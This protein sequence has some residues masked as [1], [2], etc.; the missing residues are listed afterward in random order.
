MLLDNKIALITGAMGSFGQAISQAFVNEGASLIL[1]DVVKSSKVVDRYPNNDF[2]QAD[3][4]T[5]EGTR[6]LCHR[7]INEIGHVDILINNAGLQYIS[8]VDEFPEDE[9]IKII[10]VMLVA[11]FQITKHLLPTMKK[12]EWGRIINMSSI[13]GLVASPYKSAY[14]SAKHGIVGLTK[15]VALEVGTYGITVNAICPGYSD[16]PLVRNQ[17][18]EQARIHGVSERDALQNIML[19]PAAIPELI[20][21]EEIA[22]LAVFLSSD[23][24]RSITGTAISI[25]NGWTAR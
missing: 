23:N 10:Q 24:S 16:T 19:E 25:D 11:P 1:T 21:P 9:W 14:V 20:K 3:I 6:E 12:R 13:H 15:A 22:S 2:I 8:S 17:L 7:I 18:A 4:S 5:V